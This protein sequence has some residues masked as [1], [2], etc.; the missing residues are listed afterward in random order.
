MIK[1]PRGKLGF[2]GP[3]EMTLLAEGRHLLE[4]VAAKMN[5]KD[6]TLMLAL[7]VLAGPPKTE[8]GG[9]MTERFHLSDNALFRFESL[10]KRLGL[11]GRGQD[12]EDGWEFNEQWFVGERI[13][14]DVI[15]ESFETRR[16]ESRTQSRLGTHDG[17]GACNFWPPSDPRMAEFMAGVG[18]AAPPANGNGHAHLD[19][20]DI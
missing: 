14:A 6:G 17:K 7:R 16:G 3:E 9:L 18:R 19:V 20:D 15:N 4:I 8:I 1:L 5:D 11:M 13:V 10:L 2:P 12:L